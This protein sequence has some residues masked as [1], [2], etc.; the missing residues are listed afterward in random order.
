MALILTAAL[1][2]VPVV[3]GAWALTPQPVRV[4]PDRPRR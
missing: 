4:R 2:A 1:F 3:L